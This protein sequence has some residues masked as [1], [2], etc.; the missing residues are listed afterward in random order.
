[1]ARDVRQAMSAPG[2]VAWVYTPAE[3]WADGVVHLLGVALSVAGSLVFLVVMARSLPADLYAA[4]GIYLA[5]LVLS[6]AASAVYNMWPVSRTKWIL[7]RLDHS[8]IYL[9]IA[10][11]YT[12]FMARMETWWMLAVVWMVALSGAALKLVRPGEFDRL[13]IAAYLALGWSGLATYDSLAD[14]PWLVVVLIV[15]GGL[16]Y[17][18]GVVFHVWE[19][20]RYQNVIWHSFVLVAAAIHFAAVWLSAVTAT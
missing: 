4:S 5:T 2:E 16:V 7:R 18:I 15:A 17:S 1:M 8:A 14:L 11:T 9:L 19:K 12:P 6:L 3:L 13:A 10:G 20:L